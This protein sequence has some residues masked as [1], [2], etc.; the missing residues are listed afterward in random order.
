VGGNASLN[1]FYGLVGQSGGFKGAVERAAKDAFRL[2]PIYTTGVGS[3]EGINHTF[4][5]YDKATKSSVMDRHLVLFSVPEIDTLAA[6][7]SRNGSTLL[8]QLRKA[9]SGEE[10]T[11]GYVDRDKAL[12]VD[13]HAYRLMVVAGIQPGRARS[14]LE[15]A[16]GGTPQRFV[17][18]P[19]NDPGMPHVTP[20]AP[21]LLDLAQIADGWPE[22]STIPGI[23][24]PVVLGLPEEA[25][26]L[27]HDNAVAK[28]RGESTDSALDGHLGL[29]RIKVA[30][31]LALLH[32]Q[33]EVT[34]EFWD[35]SEMVMKVSQ[36]TR[37]G[38]ERHLAEQ[39]E[40]VNRARGR[41][42][43][44]RA[45]EAENVR[46]DASVKRVGQNI[47]HVLEKLDGGSGKRSDIRRKIKA[48]IRD[49]FD[50]ALDAL[51]TAG[52]VE[53][54]KSPRGERIRL[55]SK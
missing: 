50:Y 39:N 7:G 21:K 51:V 15:D 54:F 3:G 2:G 18:L 14:L 34:D 47:V 26:K 37:A 17:W 5:H 16:D 10:L 29:C 46:E 55:V 43:G 12:R 11:F 30:A 44:V 48:D 32:G 38:V 41:A 33:R 25:R 31:A 49:L 24:P 9:W 1:Q 27:I 28:H 23:P 20:E 52:L 40:K 45:V 6:L 22:P 4:A 42:E 13:E 8:S 53:V 36:A 19:T 35:M